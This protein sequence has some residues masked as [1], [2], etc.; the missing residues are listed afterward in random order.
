M[1]NS[2]DVTWY[3]V[4]S[5]NEES[6]IDYLDYAGRPRAGL[7]S[8]CYLIRV[9]IYPLQIFEEPL[10]HG[11]FG[12]VYWRTAALS[13]TTGGNPVILLIFENIP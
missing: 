10:D 3:A 2:A 1:M 6:F 12:V 9:K 8:S 4:F 7:L 13:S 5:I 11:G